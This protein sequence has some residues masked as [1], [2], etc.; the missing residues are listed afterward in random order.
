MPFRAGAACALFVLLSACAA[1]PVVAAPLVATIGPV[2]QSVTPPPLVARDVGPLDELTA[3]VRSFIERGKR[4]ALFAMLAD[5]VSIRSGRGRDSSSYDSIYGR[6]RL[7]ALDGWAAD[8]EVPTT[9]R[10]VSPHL[11]STGRQATVEWSTLLTKADPDGTSAFGESYRLERRDGSWKIVHFEYWPLV[12]DTL[13]EFSAEYWAS[14]DAKIDEARAK[15]GDE[16]TLAYQLMIGYRFDE[17]AAVSRRLT[18]STPDEPWVW[19]MRATASALVGDQ[20][21][22]ERASDEKRR[23]ERMHPPPAP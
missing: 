17:C 10:I 16:Q 1:P 8:N 4:Q 14:T 11:A 12:P 23:L 9:L 6:A 3:A 21:D 7:V 2:A 5:D 13:E 20:I 19:G 22:A 15:K 18:D